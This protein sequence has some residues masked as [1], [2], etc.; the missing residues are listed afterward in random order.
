MNARS[1]SPPL[2]R[3]GFTLIEVLATMVLLAIVLPVAL[4]GVTLSLQAASK[5]K[6]TSIAASL[7]ESKLNDLLTQS[8]AS[9]NGASTAQQQGDFA[10]ENPDFHWSYASTS[11]DY[12]VTEVQLKV[13]WLERGHPAEFNLCT[14]T[15]QADTGGT[16]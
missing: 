10:P 4:R 1:T 9:G 12:G 7:A 13:T 15:Y 2:R 5:A 3:R 6:H 14:M 8:M 11:R 16:Q